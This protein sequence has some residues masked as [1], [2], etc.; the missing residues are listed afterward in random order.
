[1][2]TLSGGGYRF[3]QPAGIAVDGTHIWI[4]NPHG[5][6]VTEIDA[7]DGALIRTLSGGSY[8]FSTPSGIGRIRHAYLDHQYLR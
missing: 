3:N 5:N 6:S 7:A 1:M 4:T 2:R 8:R